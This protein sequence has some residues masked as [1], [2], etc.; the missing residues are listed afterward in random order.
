MPGY[1]ASIGGAWAGLL[2]G[3]I[4]GAIS[5][6]RWLGFMRAVSEHGLEIK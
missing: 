5:G 1:S 4:Y 2:W 3:A 6:A